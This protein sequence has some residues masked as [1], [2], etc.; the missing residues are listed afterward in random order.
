MVYQ[1]RTINYPVPAQAAGEHMEE[2]VEK[3]GEIT[4]QIMVDD[5]RPDGALMHPMYEWRDDIA[6][7]K[8]RH[9]QARKISS[10]LIMVRVSVND[11]PLP[12]PVRAFVSVKPRNESASYRPAVSALS[13][14]ETKQQVIA[15]ARAEIEAFERK[16]RGIIDIVPILLDLIERIGGGK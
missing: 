14:E 11:E 5:A 9:H 13:D 12:D 2:L 15:N 3:Y 6:A 8:Y 10:E 16:Y 7:E 4:P 1:W